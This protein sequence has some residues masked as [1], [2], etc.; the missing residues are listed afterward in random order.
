MVLVFPSISGVFAF[1][2]DPA[3]FAE[4][5]VNIVAVVEF[6]VG[7]GGEVFAAVFCVGVAATAEIGV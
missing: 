4:L 7:S 3:A 1:E 2:F 6:G 5:G